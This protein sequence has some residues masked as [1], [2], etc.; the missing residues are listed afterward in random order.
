GAR[1][2]MWSIPLFNGTEPRITVDGTFRVILTFSL[3]GIGLGLLYELLFRELMRGHG[4]LFGLLIALVA[5]YPLG[6]QG[7]QQ[8]R[9]VPS[10]LPAAAVTFTIVATMFVPF[11]VVLEF[12]LGKW[13]RFHDK[14]YFD[15]AV[16]NFKLS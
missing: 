13:H 5:W 9:F 2:G 1:I 7:I 12:S 16:D 8:L 4:L 14:R 3:F 6:S 10:F 11:A 15:E